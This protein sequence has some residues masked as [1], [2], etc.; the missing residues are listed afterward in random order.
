MAQIITTLSIIL[1]AM[2]LFAW[3]RIPAAAVA[4][5][6][7]LALYF[8]GILTMHETLSGFGDPVVVM[9][10]ALLA[11]A[12]GL[13][14]AGV[15]AWS[16]QLLIRHTGTNDSWRLFA[17][18][19]SAAVF[20]GL[21]GMN[22]AVAAMLPITVVVAVRT[23]VA[24][25]RLMI[26]L[27]FACLTGS[28]LTL[29]GTPVNLIAATQAD[30]GGAGHIGFFEWAVLGVPLLA[31]TIV[32]TLAFGRSLLPE[33]HGQSIPADFSAHAETLVEQY[34]LDDGLHYFRVRHTSPLVGRPRGEIAPET[35]G[36]LQLVSILAGDTL[37]PLQRPEI[38]EGDILLVRGEAEQAGRFAADMHLSVRESDTD[39]S[40]ADL[41]MSRSSGLAEVVIP[42]RSNLIGQQAFPGMTTEDG[43]LMV[44]AIQRGSEEIRQR[45]ITLRAGDHLLLQGTWKALDQYLADPKVLVVDSLEAVQRQAVA[46]GQGAAMAITVL[47]L[48]VLLLAF[49]IVPAPIAAVVCATLMVLG[50]VLTLAQF[51]RGIDWN[52]CILIGAMIPPA[53][54]MT[55]TGAA[56]L[57]G[58]HVVELLG[59]AGPHAV[60]AGI[61]VVTALI[62]QFISNTSAALVMMPIGFATASELGVSPLPLIMGVAMGASA[63]FLTPFANGVSLMVYGPGGY[64]FGDF[65]RLGLLIMAWTL[66]VTV[67]IV[68]LYWRF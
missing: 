29:L 67:V 12:T 35:F 9:I 41:L 56:E 46:L 47:L 49:D 52:T 50:R 62:S 8:S 61:F 30:E 22:G 21:I 44:L 10:A 51:Y 25:S 27:A 54:A 39:G 34:R 55:K 11:I 45:T 17:I 65:W 58:D 48:L 6:A 37:A 40:I 13:E 36:G 57:I 19:I 5:G 64:R 66:I 1:V 33:R 16:G 68:P 20:S 59:G 43:S 3:N 23:R 15:G 2:A 38:A 24:P 4:V 7:S 53:T 31:G 32:L 26:P 18:M 60:L 28:K 63:S 14:M 42:Q